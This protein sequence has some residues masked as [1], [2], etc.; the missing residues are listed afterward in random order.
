MNLN[1][2]ER[3][4]ELLNGNLFTDIEIYNKLHKENTKSI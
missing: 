1:S 4:G 2:K 3:D